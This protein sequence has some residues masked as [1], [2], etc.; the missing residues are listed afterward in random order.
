MRS[1]QWQLGI[2]GTI[3]AF[4]F[5][6]RETKKNL[7]RSGLQQDL[8]NTD[9]QPAVWHLKYK[10]SNIHIVNKYTQDNNN[11]THKTTTT[12]HTRQLQ[13]T[14][15]NYN[16]TY[17]T[18]TTIP[19]KLQQYVQ[20]NQNNTHNTTTTIHIRQLTA[21]YTQYDKY[22]W[23]L[24][25]FYV[26]CFVFCF[27]FYVFCFFVLMLYCVVLLC[28]L[29]LFVCCLFPALVLYQSTDHCHRMENRLNE[30]NM[31]LCIRRHKYCKKT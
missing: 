26:F 23:F 2:L 6:H 14:Q 1:M 17:K 5:R 30:I 3:S 25:I 4:A 27:L 13:Y 16:N 19:T 20:D 11:N 8:P 12:I 31:S 28:I 29:F 15:D 7:W 18:T 24:N 22:V 9:F 10:Y 21:M